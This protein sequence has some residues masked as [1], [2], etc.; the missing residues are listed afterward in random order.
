MAEPKWKR[1]GYASEWKYRVAVAQEQGY[2]QA[3]YDRERREQKAQSEGFTSA[4]ARARYKRQVRG[5]SFEG[6]TERF[7]RMSFQSKDR[8][9]F[10]DT[11]LQSWGLD[12]K[13]FD[14]IRSE[15]RK[16]S[17][18]NAGTRWASIQLYD[19]FVDSR[20]SD[21]SDDRIGYVLAY[22]AAMV[23][24]RKNY[25]SLKDNPKFYRNGP[26]GRKI[27][28]ASQYFYL[29]KYA[30]VMSVDEFEAR[31]GRGAI[32]AANRQGRVKP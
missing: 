30:K 4:S 16:W 25:D 24:K 3:K 14:K 23:N 27:G 15:N 2:S 11:Q 32:V 31:Y 1:L 10:R 9:R 26:Q 17:A 19:E 29:V 8:K 7:E 12:E 5:R 21:Y 28:N 6:E 20:E 22:H 18:A 13:A